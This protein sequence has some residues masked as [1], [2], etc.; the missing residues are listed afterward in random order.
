VPFD[1]NRLP[2]FD[3][4]VLRATLNIKAGRTATY[5]DIACAIGESA[6]ASRAVGSALAANPWPLLIPCHRIVSA[7]G[8]MTGFSGAGGV[9]T[10]VKLLALEGAQLLA[11]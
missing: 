4:A 8:R 9:N 6:G 5:G 7:S 11:E 10:K 3:Q 2:P 1:F